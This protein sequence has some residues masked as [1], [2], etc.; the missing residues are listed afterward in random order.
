MPISWLMGRNI[1]GAGG[2]TIISPTPT[3]WVTPSGQTLESRGII[4][5]YVGKGKTVSIFPIVN[6]PYAVQVAVSPTGS[7]QPVLVP[8]GPTAITT[9]PSTGGTTPPSPTPSPGPSP[10]TSGYTTPS[11]SPSPTPSP[12]PQPTPS[13]Q[14][15]Q[16]TG[17]YLPG[18]SETYMPSTG[19]ESELPSWALPAAILG[20]LAVLGLGIYAASRGSRSKR[21]R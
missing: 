5:T 11:P 3:E 21:R 16:E 17:G 9:P 14:E 18:I 13:T 6:K 15:T 7:T 2:K 12:S 4:S 8:I 19:T 10:S 1:R 20:G